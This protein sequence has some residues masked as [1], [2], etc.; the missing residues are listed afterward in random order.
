MLLKVDTGM[1]HSL[2]GRT[3]WLNGTSDDF[4]WGMSVCSLD[5]AGV[6]SVFVGSSSN[7]C[8]LLR[9]PRHGDFDRAGEVDGGWVGIRGSEH[10]AL[11]EDCQV[12]DKFEEIVRIWTIGVNSSAP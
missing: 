12:A 10:T 3:V 6:T 1:V 9:W 5:Q 8:A 7:Y 4:C 11:G 2:C